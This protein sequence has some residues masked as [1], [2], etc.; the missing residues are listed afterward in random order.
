M[1][2]YG[3]YQEPKYRI[4]PDFRYLVRI[5]TLGSVNYVTRLMFCFLVD[6]RIKNYENRN[7]PS[8][9]TGLSGLSPYL[10]YGHISAQRCALEAR[11][12]RKAHPKVSLCK[13][14]AGHV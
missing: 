4:T 9:P 14:L 5:F 3:F 6:R 10:H 11:K 13:C 2:P 7:D 12:F 8:K 1:S